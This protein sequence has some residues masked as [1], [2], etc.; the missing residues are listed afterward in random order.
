MLSK[1]AMQSTSAPVSTTPAMGEERNPARGCR[2]AECPIC[3]RRSGEALSRNHL[4]PSLLMARLAWDRGSA[5]GSPARALLQASALE[6]HWGNPP[7][8]AAPSATEYTALV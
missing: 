6:F 2:N 5:A 3:S 8:A 7:P 4:A 1:P